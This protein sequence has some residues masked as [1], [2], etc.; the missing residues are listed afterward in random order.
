[1]L[2]VHAARECAV[3]GDYAAALVYFDGALATLNKHAKTVTDPFAR[4]QWAQCCRDLQARAFI[5]VTG[6]PA[7]I[8][9]APA[10]PS[11]H[12]A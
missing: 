2:V 1:M 8:D 12:L 11:W 9:D 4:G 10:I 5:G 3:L 7:H 6:V